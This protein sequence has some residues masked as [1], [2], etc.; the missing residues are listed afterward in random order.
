MS[1]RRSA[2]EVS[3]CELLLARPS[4]TAWSDRWDRTYLRFIAYLD[5][6]GCRG[7]S[8][9]PTPVFVAR[10]FEAPE[11]AG[12]ARESVRHGFAPSPGHRRLPR[13]IQRALRR[14]R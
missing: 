12:T 11:D 10:R 8:R 9:G 1:A 14:P 3:S 13:R 2:V 7:G 5:G 4:I 6:G